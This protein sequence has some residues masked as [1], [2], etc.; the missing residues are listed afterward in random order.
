MNYLKDPYIRQ[1]VRRNPI[2]IRRRGFL[3]F[4]LAFILPVTQ[5]I[6]TGQPASEGRWVLRKDDV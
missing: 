3:V 6:T 5:R 2:R 4:G 1:L